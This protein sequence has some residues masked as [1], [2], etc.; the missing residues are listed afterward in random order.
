MS[1]IIP[2]RPGV[3]VDTSG[4]PRKLNEA[5]RLLVS[6]P[7]LKQVI[8]AFYSGP[9]EEGPWTLVEPDNVPMWCQ[10][11]RS[12]IQFMAGNMAQDENYG[13]LWYRAEQMEQH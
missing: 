10:E 8:L 5:Q 11:P 9:S 3:I 13:P 4:K 12:I 6:T 2:I 1:Q 7:Q